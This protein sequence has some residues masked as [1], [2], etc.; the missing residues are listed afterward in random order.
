MHDPLRFHH[1]IPVALLAL[2][3]CGRLPLPATPATAAA[4]TVATAGS[5]RW[6]VAAGPDGLSRQALDAAGA[7]VIDRIPALGVVVVRGDDPALS[8]RLAG[9]PGV[10]WVEADGPMQAVGGR[11]FRGLALL[12]GDDLLPRLWGMETIGAR[13]VWATTPG[14]RALKVAVVDT[15]IDARHADF[16]GRVEAGRDCINGDD[17]PDDDDGHG[18]HCAGTVAAGLGNGGVVGVAPG[19]TLLSVKVLDGEGG[20]SFVSVSAGIVDAADRGARVISLSLSSPRTSK[21]LEEAVAH[22]TAKGALL[23][24]A[25]GNAGSTAP[26]YPAALPQVMAVGAVRRGDMPAYFSNTGKHLSVA[27]PGVDILSTVPGGG[28]ESLDGTSM[29]CPHVAGLAALVFS[30]RPAWT[31]AQVRRRIEATAVDIGPKGFDERF[32]HGRID[33]AEALR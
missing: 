7:K 32:G 11:H 3:A 25:S 10:R 20:G 16:S 4:T 33:V 22:A 9:L 8:R 28:W 27:A 29:A 18:T 5:P 2:S 24:A 13:R 17:D 14:D 23:V 19:V 30:R 26:A 15:G 6:I 21:L 12:A 1:L 31:A